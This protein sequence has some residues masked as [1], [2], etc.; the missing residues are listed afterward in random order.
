MTLKTIKE[1]GFTRFLRCLYLLPFNVFQQLIPFPPIR[2][3]LFKLLGAKIGK[4]TIIDRVEILN[5]NNHGLKNLKIG[6]DCFIGIRTTLDLMGE[7]ELENHCGI[8]MN[9]II[10]T[11]SKTPFKDHPL[12]KTFKN[13]TK[14][15]LLK[16]GCIIGAGA[17]IL[18]GKTIGE[19]SIV[20]AGSIV[21][22]NV[23]NETI[24]AGNPAKIIKPK[25]KSWQ[26]NN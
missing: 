11:H 24:V 12:A 10:M 14:K 6:E 7:I 13:I 26:K 25:L 17:I 1:L 22:K 8:A 20:G 15:T 19:K 2:I 3:F 5:A 9:C 16:R 4:N 23:E 18:A 21:T